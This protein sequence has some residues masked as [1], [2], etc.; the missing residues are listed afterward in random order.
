MR[1][2]RLADHTRR[3]GHH[4]RRGP[5]L[6]L[7]DLLDLLV[8]RVLLLLCRCLRLRPILPRRGLA[9]R[10]LLLALARLLLRLR[11]RRLGPAPLARQTAELG[12]GPPPPRAHQQ[13][14]RV[15]RRL[16]LLLAAGA[17]EQLE[18]AAGAASLVHHR[19]LPLLQPAF[20]VR[21]RRRLLRTRRPHCRL[22][23]PRLLARRRRRLRARIPARL[24][25]R[26]DNV[27]HLLVRTL[28]ARPHAALLARSATGGS[29]LDHT[30]VLGSELESVVAVD[31]AH[32]AVAVLLAEHR[33]SSALA[34]KGACGAV[35]AK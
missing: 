25:C 27:H 17:A 7:L 30:Q 6:V 35:H 12:R 26:R 5:G 3:L 9:I 21:R 22:G 13:R 15:G 19:P 34:P 23:L 8:L 18:A 4:T 28:R 1:A 29:R 32:L 31:E 14:Q 24:R 11:G 10:L 2:R 20:V 16:S 33:R